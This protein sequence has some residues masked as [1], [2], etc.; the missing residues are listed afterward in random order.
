M[1]SF[2][3]VGET[4]GS[5]ESMESVDPRDPWERSCGFSVGS[6]LKKIVAPMREIRTNSLGVCLV[7]L[8]FYCMFGVLLDLYYSKMAN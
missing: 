6:M 3:S 2:E 7:S 5:V 1:G 8:S 4:F